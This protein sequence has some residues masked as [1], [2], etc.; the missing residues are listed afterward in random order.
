MFCALS[1]VT[2]NWSAA[3][4]K[5]VSAACVSAE[6]DEDEEE[7]D[8]DILLVENERDVDLRIDWMGLDAGR[9]AVQRRAEALSEEGVRR[10][11]ARDSEG[12]RK[13]TASNLLIQHQRHQTHS[14]K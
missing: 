4:L 5:C 7:E 3:N 13:G 6:E 2:P 12:R 8:E 11:E 9:V 1:V 10:G 14:G